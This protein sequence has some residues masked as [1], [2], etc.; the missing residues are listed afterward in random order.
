MQ[1]YVVRHGETSVNAEHRYLGSLDP[2]LTGRGRQQA[3]TLDRQ[4]A[5]GSLLALEN[6]GI[7]HSTKLHLKP[8]CLRPEVDAGQPDDHKH[9]LLEASS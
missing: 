8:L 7:R 4:L 1:L 5:N 6:F 9:H 3:A 2:A